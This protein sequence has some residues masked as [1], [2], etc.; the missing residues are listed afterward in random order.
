MFFTNN[1]KVQADE[2]VIKKALLETLTKKAAL[3][4]EF[5]KSDATETMSQ[6]TQ[7]AKNVNKS[8]A[9]RLQNIESN[10]NLVQELAE[11]SESMEALSQTSFAST[12]E[13]SKQ[14]EQST[15]QLKKLSEKISTA[16]QNISE[17]TLLL[18]GLTEN[19]NTISQ[20][21]ESIKNIASQTNLLALN[22]AIE[23]ARA[24][25]HGRGFAVVA[26]EVRALASTA[27]EAAE[28]IHGE[29]SQIME[30]SNN[31]IL[32]QNSVVGSIVESRDISNTIVGNLD[33][34]C[35]LSKDSSVSAESVIEA[36]RH[37]VREANQILVNIG[38]IVEDTR[39]AVSGSSKN[40][41][42]GQKMQAQLQSLNSFR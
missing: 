40:I 21:V 7:N 36:A 37:Q 31:I 32:Q 18:E 22:A 29:M 4:D 8:S 42:L 38:N 24:G 16:E 19:N 2:V 12:Q 1:A 35:T 26:G 28:K 27:N 34:M 6:I 9:Q 39:N 15:G 33:G 41:E 30:I 3:F 14:S 25:E 23:A 5:V 20:L 10:Y 13:M 17:F 11:Q